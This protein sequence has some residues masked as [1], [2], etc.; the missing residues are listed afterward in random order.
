MG[1]W[2]ACDSIFVAPASPQLARRN[3]F[4]AFGHARG[5]EEQGKKHRWCGARYPS[6]PHPWRVL[7]FFSHATSLGTLVESEVRC[8]FKPASEVMGTRRGWLV[9]G[10]N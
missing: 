2:R 5:G 10:E 8:F 3:I 4:Q 7:N 6:R 1:H 9:V